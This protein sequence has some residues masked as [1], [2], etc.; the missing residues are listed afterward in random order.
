MI[1]EELQDELDETAKAVSK[2]IDKMEAIIDSIPDN[3][4][5]SE[6]SEVRIHLVEANEMISQGADELALAIFTME[7]ERDQ[8]EGEDY[9]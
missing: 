9:E 6:L 2:G 1:K 8:R 3:N 5:D 4:E 7:D